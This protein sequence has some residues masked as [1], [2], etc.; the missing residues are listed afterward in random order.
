MGQYNRLGKRRAGGAWQWLIIGFFPGL[1]CGGLLIFLLLWNGIFGGLGAE[2]EIIEV[3][4]E[5]IRFVVTATLDPNATELVRIVTA[6]VD[7]TIGDSVLVQPTLTPFPT[8]VAVNAQSQDAPTATVV[9]SSDTNGIENTSDTTQTDQ[10]IQA[11]AETSIPAALAEIVGTLVQINGGVFQMGTDALT[12]AEEAQLCQTRDGGSCE[13]S[14]GEDATPQISIEL[15]TFWIEQ[16]EVTFRQYVAFL[17]Y[18]KSLGG[19]HTNGCKDSLCIQTQN[20]RPNAAVIAFDG[21]SYFIPRNFETLNNHP[22]YGVTWYGAVS[23]CEALGRRLP[24]EAEWEYAARYNSAEADTRIYPWGNDW[25]PARANVRISAIEGSGGATEAI[26]ARPVG[27]SPMGLAHMSGNVAEW[28][29]DYYSADY[30]RDLQAIQQSSGNP[31]GNPQGPTLGLQRV[32]RGGSFD[33]PPFFARTVHRQ[34]S[35]P[36]PEN[37]EDTFPLWVGFRCASDNGPAPV[38]PAANAVSPQD[39]VPTQS[40]DTP[41][42]ATAVAPEDSESESGDGSRG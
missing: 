38:I 10:S 21:A 15:D 19:T 18:Q 13:A 35:N 4:G 16:N 26:D 29:Q 30:Y 34:S 23:Y 24:S 42:E 36:A 41:S 39:L 5:P 31:V 22:A 11:P 7:T 3:T 1:L 2:P 12:N 37:P 32:L 9:E 20:E 27:N 40:T 33:T 14:F 28:V 6:T 25:D 8:A 17:N